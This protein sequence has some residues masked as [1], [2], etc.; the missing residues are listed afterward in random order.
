MQKLTYRDKVIILVVLIISVIIVGVML[1]IK[2]KLKEIDELKTSVESA[3]AE[4]DELESKIL[5][6]NSIKERIEKKYSESVE[7]GNHFV[8][9][10]EAHTLEKFIREFTDKNGIYIKSN[11]SVSNASIGTLSP[12]TIENQSLNYSIADSAELTP[13]EGSENQE[14][15]ANSNETSSSQSLPC[16][17][18]SIDYDTTRAGLMQFLQD[19]KDSGKA[20]EIKSLNIGGN[21]Y[22]NAPDAVIT[23]DISLDVYC[24]Q[25]ISDLD[26]NAEIAAANGENNNNNTDLSQTG[27]TENT[28]ASTIG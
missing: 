22:S 7:L 6:I 11:L 4:W 3:Q 2:P 13:E 23:G 28:T 15:T 12:Y 18:F 14:G 26:I 8:D 25:M 9:V 5:Q 20:I 24:A 1:L 10:K 21:T 19:I 17:T 27:S 16:G